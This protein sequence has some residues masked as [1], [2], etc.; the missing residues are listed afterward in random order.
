MAEVLGESARY[1]TNQSIKKYQGA[2]GVKSL[3]LT[4]LLSGY[5]M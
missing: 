2:K 3:S 4:S 5:S 1:V